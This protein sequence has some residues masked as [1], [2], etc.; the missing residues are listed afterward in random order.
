M[1]T[2]SVKRLKI[3]EETKQA[4]ANRDKSLDRTDPDCPTMPPESW[5]GATIG[6][7]QDRSSPTVLLP[8]GVQN[9]V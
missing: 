1:K 7:Y 2:N 5:D 9:F 3:S 6:K 4:Y 8:E